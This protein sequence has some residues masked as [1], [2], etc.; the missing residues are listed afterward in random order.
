MNSHRLHGFRLIL[1]FIC[2][3]LVFGQV[4]TTKIDVLIIDG[5]S[6]HDW[7]QAS[8]VVKT[9]LEKSIR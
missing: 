8:H 9:I 2:P 1:L 7:K 6:N 4:D 5:F 3:Y